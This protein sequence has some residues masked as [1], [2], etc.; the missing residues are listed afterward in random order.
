V[1]FSRAFVRTGEGPDALSHWGAIQ[2]E[3]VMT[4]L[5]ESGGQLVLKA[6][7]PILN[8]T[9]LTLD[10]EREVARLERVSFLFLRKMEAVPFREIDD[11]SVKPETD[12]ASGAERYLPVLRLTD[13]RV[14]SLPPI[15]DKSE[16]EQTA[17]RIRKFVGLKH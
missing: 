4:N 17:A 9:T 13:G 12:G 14:L 7:T 16:A 5:Q 6:G 1:N 10:R 2:K 8:E 3:A 15:D 11:L